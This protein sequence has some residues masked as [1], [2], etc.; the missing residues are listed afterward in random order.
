MHCDHIHVGDLVK[1]KAGMDI[2]CDGILVN[3]G[4]I[5]CSGVTANES[6]MTGEPL[7]LPKET[8]AVCL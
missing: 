8:V 2:P 5:P 7:E 1:V 6:A 3:A 4:G